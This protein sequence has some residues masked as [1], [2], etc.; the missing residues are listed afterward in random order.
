M[1]ETVCYLWS[2]NLT[3]KKRPSIGIPAK[4]DPTRHNCVKRSPKV[5][6]GAPDP[7]IDAELELAAAQARAAHAAKIARLAAARERLG[8]L[9]QATFAESSGCA[10]VRCAGGCRELLSRVPRH[11]H[12]PDTSIARDLL[13]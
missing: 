3:S 5:E 7:S 1:L 13:V 6:E 8:A 10:L 9:R 4:Y 11:G 2:L 12:R